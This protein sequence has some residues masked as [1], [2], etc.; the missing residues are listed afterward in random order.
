MWAQRVGFL[1]LNIT[2]WINGRGAGLTSGPIWK[3][4]LQTGAKPSGQTARRA[5]ARRLCARVTADRTESEALMDGGLARAAHGV[6]ESRTPLSHWT[7][8]HS[9]LLKRASAGKMIELVTRCPRHT[10]THTESRVTGTFLAAQRLR[11]HLAMRRAWAQS[12]VRWLRPRLLQRKSSHVPQPQGPHA[13]EPVG[14][15]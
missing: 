6:A 4:S 15:N 5:S 8:L 12:L 3:H 2:P 1:L 10:H 11:S 9:D 13:L 14:H 7:G